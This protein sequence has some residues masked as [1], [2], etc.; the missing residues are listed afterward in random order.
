MNLLTA[1]V[2]PS[3]LLPRLLSAPRHPLPAP[4][5]PCFTAPHPPPHAHTHTHTLLHPPVCLASGS[6]TR[7]PHCVAVLQRGGG[8]GGE[9]RWGGVKKKRAYISNLCRALLFSARTQR[10]GSPASS[11]SRANR[12]VMKRLP[13]TQPQCN[14]H[15]PHLF[16][17]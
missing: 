9:G 15:F 8:G 14:L 1:S 17:L 10:N 4:T 5:P 13:A 16:S 12:N 3:F 7:Y 2:S 6:D 11:H